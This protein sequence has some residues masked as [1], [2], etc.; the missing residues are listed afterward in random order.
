MGTSG[1]PKHVAVA[2]KE[3]SDGIVEESATDESYSM[4]FA[5]DSHYQDGAVSALNVT[6]FTIRILVG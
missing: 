1:I 6:S 4:R 5:R 2:I 3:C